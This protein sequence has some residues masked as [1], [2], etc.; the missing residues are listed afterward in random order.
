MLNI[1]EKKCRIIPNSITV[2]SMPRDYYVVETER[3]LGAQ[4]IVKGQHNDHNL[5]SDICHV[6]T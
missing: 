2:L 3:G 1:K 6:Q 5:S 4:A